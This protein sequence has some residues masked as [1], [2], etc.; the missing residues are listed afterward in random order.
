MQRKIVAGKYAGRAVPVPVDAE[1]EAWLNTKA[2]EHDL[3]W[4]LAHADNGVIWG[5]LDD[6]ALR[7]SSEIFGPDALTLSW[8]TLQQARLFGPQAELR[9]WQGPSGWQAYVLSDGEGES[10]E[11]LDEEH[12]LWGTQSGKQR[13]G[14]TEFVEGSQ[15]IVHT[16]PLNAAPSNRR[17]RLLVRHYIREDD[18]GVVRI[19]LSRVV[20]LR[21]PQ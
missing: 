5:V 10:V 2:R 21:P 17:A 11:Q 4:L 9:L 13:D 14:F 18:A 1:L 20:E 7:L 8:E 15:G 6:T 12:L 16:P 3:R 19:V